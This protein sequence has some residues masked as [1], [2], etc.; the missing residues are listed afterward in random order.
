M[1]SYRLRLEARICGDAAVR[2]ALWEPCTGQVEYVGK[3]AKQA[4]HLVNEAAR[5]ESAKWNAAGAQRTPEDILAS[6]AYQYVMRDSMVAARKAA[7][8]G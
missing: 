4:A 8:R 7:T 2:I 6:W 1:E 5:I 3:M